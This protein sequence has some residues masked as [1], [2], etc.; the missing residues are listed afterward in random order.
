MQRV[1]HRAFFFF[2]LLAASH[3]AQIWVAPDQDLYDIQLALQ[4]IQSGDEVIVAPEVMTAHVR[5]QSAA[6]AFSSSL[7]S[8][9]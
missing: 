7:L 3:A 8:D 4:V 2:L 5:S 6:P 9:V 1:L